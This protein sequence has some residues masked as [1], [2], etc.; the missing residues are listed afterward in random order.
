M[1]TFKRLTKVNLND[2]NDDIYIVN[3]V[4]RRKY[5]FPFYN[6][7]ERD[8]EWDNTRD[9]PKERKYE[10]AYQMSRLRN[11][12]MSSVRKCLSKPHILFRFN[13]EE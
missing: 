13:D 6:D 9:E 11:M 4:R 10:D 3:K 7:E 5:D 8:E 2:D 1:L 12:T